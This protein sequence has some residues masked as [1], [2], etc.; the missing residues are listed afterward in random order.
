MKAFGGSLS[1]AEYYASLLK[2]NETGSAAK[3]VI[4][5][6]QEKATAV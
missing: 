3:A 5:Y 2:L 1:R 6:L 4:R